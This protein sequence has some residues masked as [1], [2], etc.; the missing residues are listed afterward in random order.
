MWCRRGT[1]RVTSDAEY[2]NSE[3]SEVVSNFKSD[4]CYPMR[5]DGPTEVVWGEYLSRSFS[6][7]DFGQM[8]KKTFFSG[9]VLKWHFNS[10]SRYSIFDANRNQK[11][12]WETMASRIASW[13]AVW[14]LLDLP[15]GTPAP[16]AILARISARDLYIICCWGALV[17][18]R[19]FTKLH[20]AWRPGYLKA[21]I[22]EGRH[23]NYV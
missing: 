12:P 1:E 21:G 5:L 20:A 22:P 7:S 19:K 9:K 15:L 13:L 16:S 18:F 14:G 17:L 11:Y 2:P 10:D 23:A 6:S 4:D 8:G 3:N